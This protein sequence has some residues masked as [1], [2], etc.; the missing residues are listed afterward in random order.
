MKISYIDL[1]LKPMVQNGWCRITDSIIFT[2]L[3]SNN[4]TWQKDPRGFE[5]MGKTVVAQ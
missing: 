2:Y 5:L 1:A 4:Q 3:K